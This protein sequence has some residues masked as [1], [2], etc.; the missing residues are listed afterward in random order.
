[1]PIKRRTEKKK[2]SEIERLV[3]WEE[4]WEDDK[5]EL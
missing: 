4:V 3:L 1:M 2:Y 5:E